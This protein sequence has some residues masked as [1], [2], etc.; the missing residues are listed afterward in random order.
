MNAAH[1]ARPPIVFLFSG[2]GAQYYQMGRELYEGHPVFRETL[3]RCDR[4][5]HELAGFSLI[6]RVMAGARSDTFDDLETSHPSLVAIELALYDTLVSERVAPDLMVGSSLGELVAAAIAGCC[7]R[8]AALALALD[9]AR[10]VVATCE[11]GG[12]LAVLG[13]REAWAHLPSA[14]EGVVLV[15]ENFPGHFTVSGGVAALDRL[16]GDLRR[17]DIDFVR[18]PVRFAF[19]SPAVTFSRAAFVSAGEALREPQVPRIPV[20]STMTTA[21]IPAFSIDHFASVV[22]GPIRFRD[23]LLRLEAKGPSL[24]VDCG[25]AGTAAAFVKYNLAPGSRSRQW[26]ILSPFGNGMRSLERA[27]GELREFVAARAAVC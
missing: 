20:V 12:M 2:Q 22:E 9:H 11:P 19:H 1:F 15:G 17:L 23:T 21:P 27:L 4:T 3:E 7:S 16:Q 18:L 25:P 24:Y 10:C 14:C 8:E 6:A 13:A 5:V 26:P